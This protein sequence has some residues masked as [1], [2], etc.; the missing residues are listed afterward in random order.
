MFNDC[1]IVFMFFKGCD[2]LVNDDLCIDD[3]FIILDSFYIFVLFFMNNSK[4]MEFIFYRRNLTLLINLLFI[5][6][7]TLFTLYYL[8]FIN[9]FY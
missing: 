5:I 9:Q 2:Y 7:S 6:I 4:N 8:L 3:L 1:Y